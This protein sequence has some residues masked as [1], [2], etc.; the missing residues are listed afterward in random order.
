MPKRP[1]DPF[2]LVPRKAG[3]VGAHRAEQPRTKAW[4]VLLWAVVATA[5]LVTVGVFGA[6]IYTGRIDPFPTPAPIVTPEPEDPGIV[7]TSY[8]VFILNGTPDG[9]LDARFRDLV[10]N[11]GWSGADVFAG[12]S[13]TQ[14]FTATTV[15]YLEDADEPAARGLAGVIGGARLIKSDHYS[16]PDSESQQLTIVIGLDRSTVLPSDEVTTDEE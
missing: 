12:P 14:S 11:A 7:D 6:L 9:G 2:D 1:A 15:Y 5:I 4:I 3:R 13:G 8:L 16:D 10:V